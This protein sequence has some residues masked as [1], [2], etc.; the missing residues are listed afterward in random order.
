MASKESPSPERGD[1]ALLVQEVALRDEDDAIPP[2]DERQRLGHA[3]QQLHGT[4]QHVAAG[5]EDPLD[6]G[7]RHGAV[8][9][10]DGRLDHGER[11]P[12]DAV[13][14]QLQVAPLD[15]LEPRQHILTCGMCGE[16]VHEP[17]LGPGE[18]VLAVPE[19]V[20]AVEPDDGNPGRPAISSHRRDANAHPR[21]IMGDMTSQPAVT[22]APEVSTAID[23]GRPV[24]ALESTIISHGLPRPRN[25]EVAFE[26]ESILRE[27][28][29][30]PATVG[31]LAGRPCV[32]LDP[33]QLQ[34]LASTADV[35]KVGV[36]ELPLAIA[37]GR[38]AATTVASTAALARLVGIRVLATGGLGGV[39][40]GASESFDESA[41]LGT[42]ARTPITVVCAGVKSILDVPATLERLETLGVTV[43]GYRTLRFPGFYV[44]DSGND[45][46]WAVSDPA[47]VAA[48]MRAAD[49][50]GLVS[51]IVLANPVPLEHQLDPAT[52]DALL[53]G[54]LAA[55]EREGVRGKAVTPFLLDHMFVASG[56]AS[57]EAN[58]WAV[59]N[60]VALAARVADAWSETGG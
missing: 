34:T 53:A 35:A 54:A 41:D 49:R 48:V 36:R 45:L 12:L 27:A 40:R 32:G 19:R 10:L 30:V 39:H 33:G 24:V 42:L 43:V 5:G 4:S 56:G 29:V 51:G 17:L 57:L 1:L 8:A 60:N 6:V 13:P 9:H 14:E 47:E 3:R 44:A 46:D 18:G 20:V 15:H 7:H 26:L 22:V 23:A 11:E 58:V 37:T 59:R 52:H 38:H 28:G 25:L 50:L 31:V 2:G 21:D 16:Q 55:A